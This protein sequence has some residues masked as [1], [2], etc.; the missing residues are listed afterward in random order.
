MATERTDSHPFQSRHGG[1]WATP[2]QFIAEILCE[3]IARKEK[4]DLPSK[5]WNLPSWKRT[6]MQKILEANASLKLYSPNAIL[7]F[8]RRTPMAFSLRGGWVIPILQEEQ[9]KEKAKQEKVETAVVVP[10]ASAIDEKPR[11]PFV[12]ANSTLKKLRE[13]DE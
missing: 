1:G 9:A 10:V 7:G 2:A 4:K 3:R 8:L 13:L 11:A 12:S 6:Y 5:F